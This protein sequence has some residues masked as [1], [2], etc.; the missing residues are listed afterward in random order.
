MTFK[1]HWRDHL[2]PLIEQF[3]FMELELRGNTARIDYALSEIE[4]R[5]S[6]EPSEVGESRHGNERVYISNPIT[7]QYEV[8]AESGVVLIYPMKHHEYGSRPY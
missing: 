1:V 7:V 3:A 6:S 4:L 5:L 2:I 8:F